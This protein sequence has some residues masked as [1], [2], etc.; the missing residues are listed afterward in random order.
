MMISQF[1]YYNI[2]MT[3]VWFVRVLLSVWALKAVQFDLDSQMIGSFCV[4]GRTA[5]TN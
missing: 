3:L 4:N 2:K 1:D 5:D